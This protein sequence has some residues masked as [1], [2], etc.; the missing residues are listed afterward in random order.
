[1]SSTVIDLVRKFPAQDALCDIHLDTPSTILIQQ[2]GEPRTPKVRQAFKDSDIQQLS[3]SSPAP[4][5]YI[6]ECTMQPSGP[7]QDPSTSTITDAMRHQHSDRLT[8]RPS[9]I[10]FCIYLFTYFPLALATDR[11]QSILLPRWNVG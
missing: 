3:E 11:K 10:L 9:L 1:M 6:L 8:V 2:G 7:S 5:N 4:E